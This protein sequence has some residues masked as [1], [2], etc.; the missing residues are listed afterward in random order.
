M[1]TAEEL[2][3]CELVKFLKER[4]VTIT[5]STLRQVIWLSV[6]T[7]VLRAMSIILPR[8]CD[9]VVMVYYRVDL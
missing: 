3:V 9:T 5:S 8:S 7:E 6:S 1:E 2:D 4:G